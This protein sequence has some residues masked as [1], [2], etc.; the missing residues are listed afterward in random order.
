MLICLLLHRLNDTNGRTVTLPPIWVWLLIRH[1]NEIP[2]RCP[3]PS[4][5][6]MTRGLPRQCL[7]LS[8][9]VFRKRLRVA[10]LLILLITCI[11]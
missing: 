4:S 7:K 2:F 5:R 10:R 1:L 3:S 8:L 11:I 6:S 9:L